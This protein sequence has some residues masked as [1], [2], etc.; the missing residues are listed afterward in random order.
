MKKPI[1]RTILAVVVSAS[2]SVVFSQETIRPLV[3]EAGNLQYAPKDSA[4]AIFELEKNRT[5]SFLE[6]QAFRKKVAP[7]IMGN[8]KN[9]IALKK[10]YSK[11]NDKDLA[12]RK[13]ISQLEQNN[14]GL[15]KSLADYEYEGEYA[16]SMFKN[17]FNYDMK[18]LEDE[19]KYLAGKRE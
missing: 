2:V 19:L 8:E 12:A 9:I 16:W 7:Q 4:A 18:E 3:M 13:E 10:K 11:L 1:I 5:D 6:F 14:D 15:K 17:R